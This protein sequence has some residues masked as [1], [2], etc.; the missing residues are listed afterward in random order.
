MST[1]TFFKVRV[2]S[3]DVLISESNIYIFFFQINSSWHLCFEMEQIATE[4]IFAFLNLVQHQ[5]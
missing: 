3:T 4:G 1:S 2:P 5:K